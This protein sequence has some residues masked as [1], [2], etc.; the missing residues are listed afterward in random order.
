MKRMKSVMKLL[1]IVATLAMPSVGRS[2]TPAV[3]ETLQQKAQAMQQA[4]AENEQRLHQYQWIETTSV[5][6]NGTPRPSKQM[7][8]RYSPY[9]TLVKTPIGSQSGPPQASGGP[10]RRHIVEKKIEKAEQELAATRGLTAMYLP[11]NAGALKQAMQIRRVDFEHKPAGG[12]AL[13]IN[14]YA[15]Q[16]DKLTLDL[17]KA[18]FQLRRIVVNSYFDSPADV[19]TATVQFSILQDGTTY[20]SITTIEVPGKKLSITTLSSSF[21]MP[22]Q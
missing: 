11:L 2:Q 15:K 5:T 3:S 20:P 6:M 16:G 4:A 7:I 8:C 21:S 9:G 1:P 10:L 22:V 13:V 14:D 12:N 19:F 17:D 18:T